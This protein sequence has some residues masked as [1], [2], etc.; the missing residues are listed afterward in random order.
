MRE[1]PLLFKAPMV[2]AVINDDK[3]ETRRIMKV[4]P[5][6][7]DH[8]L[9]KSLS[10]KKSERGKYFWHLPET[11]GQDSKLFSCP[12]GEAGDRFWV[13]ETYS[14]K[15][16]SFDLL[17][18]ADYDYKDEVGKWKPSI[19][20]PRTAS[21][22]ILENTGIRTERLQDIT[23][24]GA[25]AEGGKF[26]E[27]GLNQWQQVNPG[28]SHVGETHPDNCLGTAKWSYANLWESINGTGSWDA[29]PMVWVIGFKK[30][31]LN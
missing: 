28:W 15:K 29:N 27:N 23:E 7:K 5:P 21:R 31:F 2:R 17:Y 24:A 30:A 1:I 3:T 26:T 9:V 4:Q 18:R 6:T 14:Q 19:F 16:N 12:Y 11:T 20:M 25:I 13:K 10:D 8:I 22:L